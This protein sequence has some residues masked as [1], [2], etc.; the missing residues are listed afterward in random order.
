MSEAEALET[1]S[2]ENALVAPAHAAA[3][4]QGARHAGDIGNW[5]AVVAQMP[6]AMLLTRAS[7]GKIFFH[8]KLAARLLR[9]RGGDGY[10]A[11]SGGDGYD[12]DSGGDPEIPNF[13]SRF[14]YANG[15]PC[16]PEEHPLLLAGRRGIVTHSV[17]MLYRDRAGLLSFLA[18][19]ASPLRDAQGQTLAVIAT[20]ENISARKKGEQ[21][22]RR[23]HEEALDTLEAFQVAQEDLLIMRTQLELE[24]QRYRELFQFATDGYLVTDMRGVIREA[25]SEACAKLNVAPEYVKGKIL[26]NYISLEDRVGFR[27]LLTRMEH[28]RGLVDWEGHLT[29]RNDGLRDA[30]FTVA[31]MRDPDT[32]ELQVLRW[33]LRDITAR[34][35]L[36]R[37]RQA[38]QQRLLGQEHRAGVM[39]ERTRIAQ[40]FHDTLA[41]GFTGIAF[42]LAAAEDAIPTSP[43]QAGMKIA[44]ARQVAT[45]S[46]VEARQ[47]IRAMRS[48]NLDADNL[49][50]AFAA[51]IEQIAAQTGVHVHLEVRGAARMLPTQV[52]NDLLRIGQEAITNAI[53]HARAREIRL[54][55]H[56]EPEHA[57]LRITDD[58]Q[59]F[60][61][62]KPRPEG[63]FGL[64]G[65]RERAHRI[66]G[67]LEIDSE[68][69]KGTTIAIAVPLNHQNS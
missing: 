39:E 55:L 53:K 40:E 16:R 50:A 30:Q 35:N 19:S 45:Q 36:E 31:A 10:D 9:L 59:G 12:A 2:T 13:Y 28:E 29:P 7:S 4:E 67:H 24:R 51:L 43:E 11:D 32:D 23:R 33:L 57:L 56:Y 42:L 41:Q 48:E 58:G 69:D 64:T 27:N 5:R 65:M 47:A 6:M 66:G 63:G 61:L 25:N 49:P 14:L 20:F 21:D 17:E 34:R 15:Q 37:A 46:I 52:A 68:K 3:N 62:D 44:R 26:A 60:S 22:L 18:V 54:C 1:N 8:N 38:D